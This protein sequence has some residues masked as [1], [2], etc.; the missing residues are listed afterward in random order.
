MEWWV[1]FAWRLLFIVRYLRLYQVYYKNLE[2]LSITPPIH[3]Y[4][5]KINNSL[6]FKIKD[7]YKLELLTP[8]TMKWLGS[9]EKRIDKTKNGEN[10]PSLEVAEVVLAQ[11]NFVDNQDQHESEVLYTFTPNKSYAY[12]LIVKP[13]NSFLKAFLKTCNTD[14]DHFTRRCTVQ[15]G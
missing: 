14:F 8:E 9:T 7:G 11:C 5:D 1:W 10:V 13:R 12:L 3:I 6:V 15:S 2:A 4:I